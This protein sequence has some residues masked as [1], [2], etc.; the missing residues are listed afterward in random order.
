MDEMTKNIDVIEPIDKNE[1]AVLSQEEYRRLLA[2]LDSLSDEEWNAPTVCGEWTVKLLVAHVL[3]AAE[4]NAS[5]REFLKQAV[6]GFRKARARK[7][8]LVD[9]LNEVQVIDRKHMSP[10]ELCE[11]LAGVS[12]GAIRG[13]RRTPRLF[14]PMKLGDGT[15]GKISLGHLMDV[16]Y[17]RDLWMHRND[18]SAATGKSFDVSPAHDGRIIEDVVR[19]WASK[20]DAPF[21]LELT[22]PAGGSFQRGSNGQLIT[23]DAVEFCLVVSGRSQNTFP[24][25]ERVA[26]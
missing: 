19:E 20:H 24:L 8:D 11:R 7:S 17:T 3:G 15:G 10:A 14:R 16:V 13:R 4:S 1:M 21:V 22:G 26:F 25:A 9:G 23:L 5:F 12:D 6:R 2:L 18:I